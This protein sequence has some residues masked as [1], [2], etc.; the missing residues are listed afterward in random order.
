MNNQEQFQINMDS[1]QKYECE[2]CGCAFFIESLE[3]YKVSP[4]LSPDGKTGIV[5]QPVL[6]CLE[7]R[8]KVEFGDENE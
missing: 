4:L 6:V 7:C 1:L 3:L 2:H 5:P 8:Q